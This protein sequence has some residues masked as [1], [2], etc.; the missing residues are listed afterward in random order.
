MSTKTAKPKKSAPK[1]RLNVQTYDPKVQKKL[2]AYRDQLV[3]GID[4]IEEA[5]KQKEAIPLLTSQGIASKHLE[6][7]RK[8]VNEKTH[9]I[10]MEV[11]ALHDFLCDNL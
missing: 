1:K 7:V 9:R 6:E 3:S 2:L 8:V 5:A 11:E 4:P 10:V